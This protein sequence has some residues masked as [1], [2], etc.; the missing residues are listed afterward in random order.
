MARKLLTVTRKAYTRDSYVDRFG[1]EHPRKRVKSTRF[2]IKDR[3]APGRTPKRKRWYQPKVKL[4]WKK[5]MA[6]RTRRSNALKAHKGDV[7][8]TARSLQALANVTVDTATK[9]EASK[10]ARHF[11]RLH[12]GSK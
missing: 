3:G 10:D 2:K 8:A 6:E 9:R 5:G 12:K 11:F 1:Y 7:L 4:N